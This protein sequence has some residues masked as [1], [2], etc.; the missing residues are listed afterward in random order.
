MSIG[1]NSEAVINQ[2]LWT[3]VGRAAILEEFGDYRQNS[4]NAA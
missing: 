1:H 4:A 3:Y 2:W